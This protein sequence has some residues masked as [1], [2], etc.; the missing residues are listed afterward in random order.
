M[1]YLMYINCKETEENIN[2]II[3]DNKQEMIDEFEKEFGE[4]YCCYEIFD[5]DE[6]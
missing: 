3:G 6:E 2:E 4:K 5:F 1:K